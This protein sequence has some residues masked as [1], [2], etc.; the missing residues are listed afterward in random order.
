MVAIQA[1]TYTDPAIRANAGCGKETG[2]PVT[3]SPAPGASVT[4]EGELTL[5]SNSGSSQN[6]AP[7]ELTFDGAH[8]LT[9]HGGVW[10]WYQSAYPRNITFENLRVW[11]TDAASDGDLFGIPG[12][13]ATIKNVEIG[14]VCCSSSGIDIG[15]PAAATRDPRNVVIDHVY[16][17]DVVRDCRD[18]AP[19]YQAGCNDTNNGNHVDGLHI[20]G[21]DGLSITDSRWLNLSGQVLYLEGVNHGQFNDVLIKNNMIA[22]SG[23]EP[24]VVVTSSDD[25]YGPSYPLITGYM[26]VVHNTID[27]GLDFEGGALPSN[28]WAGPNAHVTVAGNIGQLEMPCQQLTGTWT[29]DSN[30]WS[31]ARCPGD[32]PSGRPQFVD[33]SGSNYNLHLTRASNGIGRGPVETSPDVD[34]DGHLRPVGFRSDAGASQRE[35]AAVRAGRSVGAVSLGESR[36][37]IVAFYGDPTRTSTARVSGTSARV[38]VSRYRLHGGWLNVSFAPDQKV[39]GVWTSSPFYRGSG[40]VSVGSPAVAPSFSTKRTPGCVYV[41]RSRVYYAIAGTRRPRVSSLGVYKAPFAPQCP[42]P[43][44]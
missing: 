18:L 27:G 39:V 41:K 23:G 36:G 26:K 38:R 19:K 16:V 8:R 35:T 13:S 1:G 5:G 14:P 21:A 7:S 12:D 30:M 17:H 44:K 22:S 40:V 28:Q 20:W 10:S 37:D 34:L 31:N 33:G 24:L 11:H 2:A 6:Q 42:R 15:R 9:I 29:W 25:V 4:I 43:H 32:A 3:F